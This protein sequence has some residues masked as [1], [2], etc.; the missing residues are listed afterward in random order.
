MQDVLYVALVLL[1]FF[2]S[3]GFVVLSE[4]LMEGQS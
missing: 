2:L 1:F 3:W 4:N